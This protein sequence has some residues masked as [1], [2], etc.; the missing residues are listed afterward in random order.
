M[1][2][3]FREALIVNMMVILYF[4]ESLISNCRNANPVR[5]LPKKVLHT[6]I[7][8]ETIVKVCKYVRTNVYLI[9]IATQTEDKG[10]N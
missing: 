1:I 2:Y 7:R 5:K 3:L 10:E 9:V 8:I 4:L 6:Y